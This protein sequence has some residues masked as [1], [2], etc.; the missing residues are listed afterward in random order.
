MFADRLPAVTFDVSAGG[1]SAEMN[2]VFIPGSKIDGVIQI[3]DDTLLFRGKVSWAHP[4]NTLL[5]IPSRFGV[6]FTR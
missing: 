2:Q 6:S 4:G 3:D 5:N 1:F